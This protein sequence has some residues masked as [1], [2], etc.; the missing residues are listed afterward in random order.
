MLINITNNT[1]EMKRQKVILTLGKC[2]FLYFTGALLILLCYGSPYLPLVSGTHHTKSRRS[3]SNYMFQ[4]TAPSYNMS[5]EENTRGKVVAR[6]DE[7]IRVGIHLPCQGCRIKFRIVKGDSQRQFRTLHKVIGDFAYLHIRQENDVIL[8]RER[9][10]C[11]QLIVK[12]TLSRP[13]YESVETTTIIYLNVLDQNDLLSRFNEDNYEFVVSKMSQ[14]FSSIGQVTAYDSD[15]G[16]NGEVFYSFKELNEYFYV[17]PSTGIIKIFKPL[18][19]CNLSKIILKGF[20]QDRTSRL[21]Y[22]N[23][24]MQPQKPSFNSPNEAEVMIKL[25]DDSEGDDK[26][27]KIITEAKEL[28]MDGSKEQ[29][30][31]KLIIEKS[32]NDYNI[33]ISNDTGFGEFFS[34]RSSSLN[35]Y[36]VWLIDRRFWKFFT[37]LWKIEV[38]LLDI[39][40]S[41][42]DYNGNK[43]NEIKVPLKIPVKSSSYFSFSSILNENEILP[44]TV[45]ECLPPGHSIY[46]FRGTPEYDMDEERIRYRI[47]SKDKDI[48]PF[49]IDHKTGLLTISSFLNMTKEKEFSFEVVGKIQGN[50]SVKSFVNVFLTITPCNSHHPEWDLS[51]NNLNTMSLGNDEL[52]SGVKLFILKAS[53]KDEGENGRVHYKI[54][55]KNDSNFVINPDTGNVYFKKDP[56][57]D[58]NFWILQAIAIDYGVPFSKYSKPLIILLHREG[59]QVTDDDLKV[60]Q[61]TKSYFEQKY[62]KR[63]VNVESVDKIIISEDAPIGSRFGQLK[64]TDVRTNS[65]SS[66]ILF[67]TSDQYFGVEEYTG[68]IIVINDLSK[69]LIKDSTSMREENFLVYQL[70]IKLYDALS[71]ETN[72]ELG[73]FTINIYI[74]DINNNYPLFDK[75][76]Y[77]FSVLENTPKDTL[78]GTVTAYDLDYNLGITYKIINKDSNIPLRIDPLTGDIYSLESFDREN[79]PILRYIII[80]T[81]DTDK[82]LTSFT[83]LTLVIGDVND[84]EPQ[85]LSSEPYTVTIPEDLP[86]NSL[87]TCL[88]GTDK[89]EG[90]NK[91]LTYSLVEEEDKKNF[92]LDSTTGC[93]FLK[94]DKPLDYEIKNKYIIKFKM[95][96][97]G[98]SS[99]STICT[100]EILL[101][102]V[103]ENIY[104]P[105]FEDI[106]IEATIEENMPIGTTVVTVH[107]NDTD[108]PLCQ[109]T[110]KIIDGDGMEYFEITEIGTI[111]TLRIL[112]HERKS[113]Y[114]LTV[115]VTDCDIKN[116][117]SSVSHVNI[118]VLNINDNAPVFLS[119]I[120]TATVSEDSP[121]DTIVC[122]IEAIDADEKQNTKSQI[123]YSIIRGNFQSQFSIDPRSGHVI[124]G[125]RR[126]DREAQKEYELHVNACDNGTPKLCST[127]VV[128]LY[129]TDVNDN[130]PIVKVSNYNV[131]VPAGKKGYLHRIIAIDNDGTDYRET[132]YSISGA[133]VTGISINEIGEIMSDVEVK[134]K[135]EI[136]L[137][138]IVKDKLNTSMQNVIDVKIKGSNMNSARHPKNKSPQFVSYDQWKIIQ[139]SDNEQLGQAISVLE[140]YDPDGDILL[141][142]IKNNEIKKF[143]HITNN[144]ELILL[145]PVNEIS[146]PGNE[147]II[148]FNVTDGS[149]TIDGEVIIKK[150]KISIYRPS[151]TSLVYYIE[152]S[153]DTPI[154]SILFHGSKHIKPI[155]QDVFIS[156][157][158]VY[159][160]HLY[161]S[162][163]T[164]EKLTIDP[165]TGNII[166]LEQI[167]ND[168]TKNFS[169]V[170]YVHLNG[171]FNYTMISFSVTDG[172]K[173]QSLLKINKN[174]NNKNN[175]TAF[176]SP[177]KTKYQFIY[178]KDPKKS[179]NLLIKTPATVLPTFSISEKILECQ[180]YTIH[181]I[182]GLLTLKES[183]KM[184]GFK[185]S[186]GICPLQIKNIYG[187]I[188]ENDLEMKSIDIINNPPIFSKNIYY[189]AIYENSLPGSVVY[190][191]ES[192]KEGTPLNVKAIDND[193]G[194]NGMVTYKTTGK[195]KS[196]E[197]FSVDMFTGIIRST[198]PIDREKSKF[199]LFYI[200]AQDLGRPSM[201]S[202]T[203]ALI[204]VTILN[205]NDCPPK[206]EKSNYHFKI[207]KPFGDGMIIGEIKAT[208]EDDNSILHYYLTSNDN[209][210]LNYF[211]INNTNGKI[212]LKNSYL[213]LK[214]KKNIFNLVVSCSDSIYTTKE[215]ITIEIDNDT[216]PDNNINFSEKEYKL[217]IKENESF[218]K[219]QSR[220]PLITLSIPSIFPLLYTLETIDERFYIDKNI[221]NIYLK[222]GITFDKEVTDS[223]ELIIS[224]KNLFNFNDKSRAKVIIEI[225]DVNDC[226]PIFSQPFY[227]GNIPKDAIYGHKIVSIKAID[228]DS[229]TNGM[230][231]YSVIGDVPDFISLNKN[232]GRV[233]VNKPI[234]NNYNVGDIFNLTVKATDK[235]IPS[236]SSTS[237]ILMKIVDKSLPIF[238]QNRYRHKIKEN[239]P[240]SNDVMKVRATSY[241]NGTIGYF[242]VTTDKYSSFIVS[243]ETGSIGTT[244]SLDKEIDDKILLKIGAVDTT[245]PKVYS[246]TDVEVDVINVNDYQPKFEKNI[247]RIEVDE[248]ISIGSVLLQVNAFDIDSNSSFISYS[249]M[250]GNDIISIEKETGKVILLKNLDYEKQNYYEFD[251]KASDEDGYWS[252][253]VIIITVNDINDNE[254]KIL[255]KN[256]EIEVKNRIPK[257][258]DLLY[259]LTVEDKDTVSSL[260]NNQRFLFTIYEDSL[261]EIDP[262]NGIIAF[263]RDL[264][265]EELEKKTLIKKLNISVTD[266]LFTDYCVLTIIFKDLHKENNGFSFEY[267]TYYGSLNENNALNTFIIQISAINGVSPYT[268]EIVNINSSIFNL[269]F[270]IDK[271]NGRITLGDRLDYEIK[272]NYLIPIKA[273]DKTGSITYTQ[274]N[275]TVLDSNDNSPKFIYNTKNELK[276][277]INNNMEIGDY[278]T[279]I[280]ATDDDFKDVLEYSINKDYKEGEYFDIHSR[281]GLISLA[282]SVNQLVN[283]K[284]RCQV[285]VSDTA[286]PPHITSMTIIIEVLPSNI[287][288]PHFSMLKYSFILFNNAPIGSVVGIVEEKNNSGEIDNDKNKKVNYFISNERDNIPFSIDKHSGKIIVKKGLNLITDKEISFPV[289]I[290]SGSSDGNN[291]ISM[292]TVTIQ[293]GYQL[294]GSPQFFTT[295][296]KYNVMENLPIGTVIGI[297]S[298]INGDFYELECSDRLISLCPFGIDKN[299]G[300]IFV[301][302]IIDREI[303]DK[304]KLNI[305]SI[306]SN[307]LKGEKEVMIFIEDENDTPLE[308][309]E[310][311]R[312]IN[313]DL[314]KLTKETIIFTFSIIDKDEK[315]DIFARITEGNA[316]EIY[317]IKSIKNET[318]GHNIYTFGVIFNGKSNNLLNVN[319][320]YISIVVSDGI[321]FVEKNFLVIYQNSFLTKYQTDNKDIYLSVKENLSIGT[322]LS[323]LKITSRLSIINNEIDKHN[324]PFVI[325]Q[326]NELVL[327]KI[328]N[329]NEKSY[330]NFSIKEEVKFID[331]YYIHNI[332]NYNIKIV[333]INDHTPK[334]IPNDI[335]KLNVKENIPANKTN[336]YFLYKYFAEDN[337]SFENANVSYSIINNEEEYFEMNPI[338]GILSLIK[339]LD[340]ETI[341]DIK[342]TIKA[343]DN[344]GRFSEIDTIL[345]IENVND[346][347]PI[348]DEKIY[349]V[350]IIENILPVEYIV[351]VHATDKDSGDILT[352]KLYENN[353]Y[354]SS[355]VKIDEK[356]GEIFLLQA[357]DYEKGKEIIFKVKVSD[358]YDIPETDIATVKIIVLDDNDNPPKFVQSIFEVKV[359]EH[360]PLGTKIISLKAI[361]KDTGHYGGILYSLTGDDSKLFKINEEGDLIVEGDL[362]YEV[363][364]TLSFEVNARD[365][366]EPPLTDKATIK[367]NIENINDHAPK[368]DNC[369][370]T[371]IIQDGIMKGHPLL[372]VFLTDEDNHNSN[373]EENQF[374]LSISGDGSDDFYFDNKMTLK[375]KKDF[376]H[377]KKDKYNLEVTAYDSGNLST[378]CPLTIYYKQQSKHPPFVNSFHRFTVTSIMGEFLG[379]NIGKIMATDDDV[380]DILI[381]SI[382][383]HSYEGY[384]TIPFKIDSQTGEISA[385]P[386]I[387][388]GTYKFPVTVTDGKYIVTTIVTVDVQSIN[389]ND[390]M[391]SL[392]IRLNDVDAEVFVKDILNDFTNRI[393]EVFKIDSNNVKIL[394]IQSS[395][396]NN[397]R[398]KRS[399]NDIDV[400]I[401]IYATKIKDYLRPEFVMKRLEYMVSS[402]K[403]TLPFS[404]SSMNHDVCSESICHEGTCNVKIWLDSSNYNIISGNGTIFTSPSHLRTFTCTC[405]EGF[406]GRVCDIPINKCSYKKC[407]R[408]EMCIPIFNTF[409]QS[410]FICSCPP[411]LEGV[412][413][414]EKKICKTDEKCSEYNAISINGGGFFQMMIGKSTEQRLNLVFEFRTISINGTLFYGSGLTDYNYLKIENGNLKY[415]WNCGTGEGIIKI[416][417]KTV[418]DGK[419]HKVMIYRV[420][421]QATIKLDDEFSSQGVSGIG[422]DVINLYDQANILTFGGEI[423]NND[424]L[425]T[426]FDLIDNNK[427]NVRSLLNPSISNSISGCIG[428]VLLDDY[429]LPKTIEGL[430]VY[431]IKMGCEPT[432]LGPCLEANCL[433]G[434][435]CQSIYNRNTGKDYTCSCPT[436]Y[437]GNECEL[438]L[439]MCYDNPCPPGVKCHS[440]INDFFCNCPIGFTGKTC[441]IRGNWDPCTSNPCGK[442]GTCLAFQ[443]S[444]ICNCT[445][446]Y[447]GKFCTI[448]FSRIQ[449]DTWNTISIIDTIFGMALLAVII[450]SSIFTLYMCKKNKKI[451]KS[452]VYNELPNNGNET[453]QLSSQLLSKGVIST[454][455]QRITIDFNQPLNGNK[456]FLSGRSSVIQPPQSSPMNPPPPLPPRSFR[457]KFNSGTYQNDIPTMSVKPIQ[458]IHDSGIDNDISSHASSRHSRDLLSSPVF[459]KSRLLLSPL[460]SNAGSIQCLDKSGR[461]VNKDKPSID[462]PLLHSMGNTIF[463]ENYV[464]YDGNGKIDKDCSDYMTIKPK[465]KNRND[466]SDLYDNEEVEPLTDDNLPPP[467][468]PHR[469]LDRESLKKRNK[470]DENNSDV[471]LYDN[472]NND[473]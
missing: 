462:L 135:E 394:S 428:K 120:Y 186:F 6:I 51:F 82:P 159:G 427:R 74:K 300:K 79:N 335:V 302:G 209:N 222:E 457:N 10:N 376:T 253:G 352:Y 2:I 195:N 309:V 365:G 418:S 65:E 255:N 355:L 332:M 272:N 291:G 287:I 153:E 110:Y 53:D 281:Q 321:H 86:N 270:S 261:F 318:N 8:N 271:D 264:T 288:I 75:W 207:T 325:N 91:E 409:N 234:S 56:L 316:K 372:T 38:L 162:I 312:E 116:P 331:T 468:P 443:S 71:D 131:T 435:L 416:T 248:S 442:Y 96:D 456:G 362:D 196:N 224:S 212:L 338:S 128:I 37:Q 23:P 173:K 414:N 164:I 451:K 151:F 87:I 45:N 275:F 392:S 147:F 258:S 194:V 251:I 306:N 386:D 422:S 357:L 406:G 380:N 370:L 349:V 60:L 415:I 152:I 323:M 218:T 228:K 108:D 70:P 369:N 133:S 449:P 130:G 420:G 285:K 441:Q 145:I 11:Y 114:Y 12:A 465:K 330:Y 17:E 121:E 240:P 142:E 263:G 36:E 235:G 95:S 168:Q 276:V 40:G 198:I 233:I 238:S 58:S 140:T 4:F 161:E 113:L 169:I 217:I 438:D 364:K 379:K 101:E 396:Q 146:I 62:E 311:P 250:D 48:L 127:V 72:K 292:A 157:R 402:Q 277:S 399:N 385:N 296:N 211:F 143:F 400:L 345:F 434:G 214:E 282:K 16:L 297:V 382:P 31:A 466:R 343:E 64:V 307:G 289:F 319:E 411:G 412:N 340:K 41:Q 46:I 471:V 129:I 150:P 388:E 125:K 358:N 429:E 293:M 13:H 341:D 137:E 42:I 34:L 274:L 89:D 244:K 204:N 26:K 458:A 180:P 9:T 448:P 439:N 227:E 123:T 432:S 245:N 206:F 148:P 280:L 166:L 404:I 178:T 230:V 473:E 190:T 425:T 225:E 220:K 337:D 305:I 322:V 463:Q 444:F 81:D 367:I 351:K 78:I 336:P 373:D 183:F 215:K 68:K 1:R 141:W 165:T 100:L 182:A 80:A 172:L 192:H 223:I 421:R 170:I 413:C 247:Y 171:K 138:I 375:T 73:N 308:F 97:N 27:F 433:N 21:F 437:S 317:Q 260:E 304:Y 405:K 163:Y 286:N 371:A 469:S 303:N 54:I 383:T 67:S 269:P 236:L 461:S 144:G 181:P 467:L 139:L 384:N 446:G 155:P 208:D 216:P 401:S 395:E 83:N 94:S 93:I 249:L 210:D 103:N 267:P 440:L 314:N 109:P 24:D 353:D 176:I 279:S 278:I 237:Y 424:N 175:Q 460:I 320:E 459:N 18:N 229:G 472:P 265:S 241:S 98:F 69:L 430:K 28:K 453:S 15:E 132:L 259:F 301:S 188:F 30:V 107:A 246:Y 470:E 154:G 106:E 202:E 407:T 174:I 189:G 366:G 200:Y 187:D 268:Y 231:K 119:P 3:S 350:E 197:Y 158:L 43:I 184:D 447:S 124:R 32:Q 464:T 299:I 179:R 254:V 105:T 397:N 193:N 262:L 22:N 90:K 35:N 242:L 29:L 257:K 455:N 57:P 84:N 239:L 423:N 160:F 342:L 368:F 201:I 232:D 381:Y 33:H 88:I 199:Q 361:D 290:S 347:S 63:K 426:I 49:T 213:L 149:I 134:V 25:I 387:L 363:L 374:R 203:F 454:D 50:E 104:P 339:P 348:F 55:D 417:K 310:T 452:V 185:F 61:T 126:L 329:W 136:Q 273:T 19:R 403:E 408:N 7:K 47:R 389:E 243:F 445:N 156:K 52:K 315:N 85:C 393:A 360:T 99:L 111:K 436:R 77:K 20:V 378:T 102:D 344:G 410:D 221:G 294:E 398:S 298:A 334:F 377:N 14:P 328:L 333:D 118:K 419:W 177:V 252:K 226:Q 326:K 167:D 117:L 256:R 354:I 295:D 390:L 44:L 359:K 115:S 191:L 266:G 346:N 5:I 122:K 66:G 205:I 219:E 356:T 450:C 112:D 324:F 313:V 92:F 431:N 284:L 76:E 327:S 59:Y 391:H 39:I 283:K